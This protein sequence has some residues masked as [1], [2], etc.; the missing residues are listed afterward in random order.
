MCGISIY[1]PSGLADFSEKL[2]DKAGFNPVF[3]CV[4]DPRLSLEC[5]GPFVGSLIATLPV[6]S[7]GSA[8]RP[9]LRRDF[10][11]ATDFA[12]T[13][14]PK[15]RIIVV[16]SA[17]NE[18]SGQGYVRLES[19]NPNLLPNTPYLLPAQGDLRLLLLTPYCRKSPFQTPEYARYASKALVGLVADAVFRAFV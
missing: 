1:N 5:A 7:Y 10:T 19:G 15:S 2:R 16:C 14:H 6:L 9:I 12:R 17:T 11:F 13:M 3:L 4:G 18:N 8:T